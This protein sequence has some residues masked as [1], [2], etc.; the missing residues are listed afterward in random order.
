MKVN[1]IH[2]LKTV[3]FA[4]GQEDTAKKLIPYLQGKST[5]L[6]IIKTE[7]DEILF[8]IAEEIGNVW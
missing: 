4:L 7:D 6:E 5:Y 3:I 1:A 2:R 8:A